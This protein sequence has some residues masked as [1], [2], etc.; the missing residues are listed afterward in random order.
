MGQNNRNEFLIVENDKQ[1]FIESINQF[2]TYRGLICGMPNERINN[3]ILVSTMKRATEDSFCGKA[4]LLVP[5][6][7]PIEIKADRVYKEIP[8]ALP[9]ITCISELRYFKTLTNPDRFM[10]CMCVVWFQD[11]YA[12]PIDENIR[13]QFKSLRWSAIAADLI[14]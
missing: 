6:Q 1:V 12:F 9:E 3:D 13:R 2:H 8:M 5:K 4:H 7:K 14:V 10:S 11:C